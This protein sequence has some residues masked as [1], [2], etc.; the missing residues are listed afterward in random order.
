MELLNVSNLSSNPLFLSVILLLSLSIWLKLAKGRNLNLPPSPP[1]LPIIGNIHQL[2]KLP[3][4]SLR[5]LSNKYGSLL[6]LR[7]G[8]NPTLVVSAVD[9]AREIVKSHDIVFSDRPRTTAVNHL[10]YES[11]GMGFTPYGEYW[12]Q[13]RKMSV[14]ELLSH[15]RVHSFQFVRDEEIGAVIN[16]IRCASLKGEPVN[17]TK[18]LTF[19]SSNIVS[20]CILSHKNDEE[21]GCSKFGELVRRLLILF[22]GFCIGDMFPY[23]RWVDV[24][25]G[26]IPSMKALSAE[27]D[28]F[29]DQVINEH[30]AV[31][32]GAEVTHKKDFVSIIMQLLKDGMFE[33]LTQDNI[34]AILLDMFLGGTDTTISTSEWMLAELLKHPNAM[35]RV[36]QEVRNVV[37]NKSK[38]APEDIPKMEYFKCVVK[39]TLRLHPPFVFLHRKTSASVKLGGYDIPSNTSVLINVWAIHMDPEWWEKPDEFIP[40]RF[41]NTSIDFEGQAFHYVPFGIG[42]RVCPGL[43]FGVS[44]V[45]HVM[46]N[47]LYLF[48]WKLPA[49]ETAEKMDMTELYGLASSKKTPLHALPIPH[50]SF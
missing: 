9:M 27:L 29:F 13:V 45:E 24:L 47:L 50:S 32:T 36:Q 48:D 20:R 14:V 4:R 39:E 11:K 2:G 40:E 5:D 43:S 1:K 6:L 28:A 7:L 35:K 8:Y 21:D 30:R 42:R 44:S 33:N 23:L 12:R 26:Y 46:A 25:T 15:Q 10:F 19:V 34:K 31:E 41:E 49:G 18:M 3:H 37:G 22:T 38:V 16:K 17:L